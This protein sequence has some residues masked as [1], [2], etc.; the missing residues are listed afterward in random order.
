MPNVHSTLTSLFG[1]IA[2]AI[3][4]KTG[5]Q[6]AIAADSFP[7]AI[8]AIPQGGSGTKPSYLISDGDSVSDFFFNKGI[9]LDTLLAG[10]DYETYQETGAD[11]CYLGFN[12]LYAVDLSSFS[13]G[14]G[15]AVVS[16]YDMTVIY[17]TIPF[18]GSALDPAFTAQHAGW[19][20][21]EY[22]LPVAILVDFSDINETLLEH[23]DDIIAKDDIAFG[24]HGG[25]GGDQPQLNA[26]TISLSQYL[27][28]ITNPATNGNF[29]TGY[30]ILVD[31]VETYTTS[32]TTYDLSGLSANTASITVKAVGTDFEDSAASNSVT[33]YKYFTVNMYDDDETTL[34]STESVRYGL[35]P[36]YVPA[37]QDYV[38]QYWVDSNGNEVT[39]IVSNINLYA[40]FKEVEI[41]VFILSGTGITVKNAT[42]QKGWDGKLQY[43]TNNGNTWTTMYASTTASGD[44]IW[45]RGTN[46]TFLTGANGS[47]DNRLKIRGS[48][49]VC[50]GNI[51]ALLDYATVETGQ[52]PT[53]GN[54]AFSALFSGCTGL[55]SAPKLPAVTLSNNCYYM[56]FYGCTG[57][58][59]LPELPATTL[60]SLCYCFMFGNC[61]NIKISETQTGNYVNEY[62]VP[63]TGTGTE[64][65]N[66]TGNMFYGTG[67]TFTGTPT[68]NTTYYTSNTVG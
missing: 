11:A 54:Y 46:N 58:T 33:F 30:K 34:L 43:S 62:R 51:E 16:M 35:M 26:P 2:D 49:I 5:S 9:S 37:K 4:A 55:I 59:S 57:L 48:N 65:S 50:S 28:S 3:R 19:Q 10:L 14:N 42:S 60:T 12:A 61:T 68:I 67:G 38:F 7:Q 1:D 27:L 29:V 18:D 23:L 56:M 6:A 21:G 15:Y 8:A 25:G 66:A 22:S 32:N 40:Y 64:A 24:E 17:S 36:S 39:S 31:G 52:H 41:A 20:T 44:T 13:L 53:M 63:K 45:L 47:T